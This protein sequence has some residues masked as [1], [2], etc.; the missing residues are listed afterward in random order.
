MSKGNK[1]CQQCGALYV[2]A[3]TTPYRQRFCGAQCRDKAKVVDGRNR[4]RMVRRYAMRHGMTLEQ[5][6]EHRE[7]ARQEKAR[8]ACVEHVAG[9]YR[10]H[11]R[12][13]FAVYRTPERRKAEISAYMLARYYADPENWSTKKKRRRIF[14]ADA[15]RCRVCGVEVDDSLPKGHPRQAVAMHIVARAT[16]G[17]WTRENMA[18]GCHECNVKDGV[19]KTPIQYALSNL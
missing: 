14:E 13:R 1:E 5:Y 15:W 12:L 2:P 3:F 19:N 18:T 9:C 4:L 10:N 8:K 6:Q 17:E 11:S 7:N 16:G